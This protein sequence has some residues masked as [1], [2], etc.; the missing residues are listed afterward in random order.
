MARSTAP[1]RR[2]WAVLLAALVLAAPLSA[3]DSKGHLV[4]EA[5]A[6]RSL[7]EG[8]DGNS[9]RPDV[10]RD[11]INDGALE[12]PFCFDD[13]GSP[14]KPCLDAAAKNPLLEWP[15]PLTDRPD[16]AFRRQFSDAGQCFHYMATLADAQTD[17]LPGTSVP[18]GLSTTAVVRCNDLLDSLVRQI[19]VQGGPAARRSSW[20]L[21]EL[22]HAVGDS[23]SGAHAARTPDGRI[24]YLRVWQP[25][26]RLARL[27]TERSKRIP[28]AAYHT[29]NDHRDKSYVIEG[30][31]AHCEKR[32]GAPYDVP[33]ACLSPEGDAARRALAGLLVVVRDLRAAQLAAPAGT[34][35]SP[36]RSAAWRDYKARWFT[37]AHP[38]EGAA[39]AEKTPPDLPVGAY[40]FL[41]LDTSVNPTRHFFDVS[42]RGMVLKYA[43]DLNP[44]LYAVSANVGYRHYT[45]GTDRDA[46]LVGLGFDLVLPVGQRVTVGLQPVGLRYVVGGNRSDP[47]IVSRLL[48]FNYKLNDR[49]FLSVDA[50]IEVDWLK[51]K[52]EWTFGAGLTF[53]PVSHRL[54]R[55]LDLGEKEE[56]AERRDESWVP[57]PAPY[58]RLR[59]RAPSWYVVTGVTVARTPEEAVEGRHY[60]RGLVGGEVA[61]DRDRWGG[62]FRWAPA[63]S[64][65]VG[66]R[67]TAGDS[68]YFTGTLAAAVRWYALG[69]VGLSI[70][71]VSLEYGPRVSGKSEID[72][73]PGVHGSADGRYYFRA[74]SRLGVALNAGI[75]DILVE[76]PTLAWDSSPNAAGELVGFRVGFRL[77]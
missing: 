75:V 43:W 39:C 62:R 37:A 9:P 23:F 59:G 64:L 57:P 40:A 53:S 65:G 32:T 66:T 52:T 33:Y 1:G 14:P 76:G 35:T 68:K 21:Y 58:G 50:P 61:W 44:F 60:G 63:L 10:L 77:R 15:Q 19:V 70:T 4:I 69:P 74:G 42:A 51:P 17:P 3:F 8:H 20:G 11:L 22:M 56:K 12:A 27:P 6:Y 72:E 29:W 28:A 34:D 18:R 2:E 38:C 13:D 41:G 7:V 16:A 46:A 26:E 25:I 5:L 47:E 45:E 31:A 67:S 48:R 73:S 24:D 54:D 71:P 36:E 55:G 30:S 49:L